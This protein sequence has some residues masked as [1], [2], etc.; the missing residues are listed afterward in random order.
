VGRNIKLSSDLGFLR[1]G[2]AVPALQVADVDFNITNIIELIKKA[3]KEGVQVLAFPE[4]AVTG[5]TIGDLVQHQALLSK[6][7]DGL[8]AI[9]KTSADFEMVLIIGLPL[10]I[11]QK[12]FNC[13]AVLNHGQILGVIPKTYL[14]SYKEF[15]EERWFASSR[16]ANSDS[17]ELSGQHV[18]FGTDILF[19]IRGI[20]SA[21]VG[22]E[23]CEDMWIPLSPHE[24]QSKAG[25]TILVNISA[26][27]EILAKADWRR[28]MLTSESGRCIAACCYVSSGI[29]E[30]T[31]DV[32]FG[33]HALI[34]ENGNILQESQRLALSPQL[35]IT[36]IDLDRL[37]NDRRMITSFHESPG[38][39]M[40]YRVIESQVNDVP[41]ARLYRSIDPHPFVP[42]DT[43]RR[44]ER[45]HDIFA[46]QVASLAKKLTGAKMEHLVLG[47][48]GGLDSTLALLVA[49]KTVDFLGLPR[50]NVY[51][52]TLPGFGTTHRT[53]D[54][55]LNLCKALG[56][57]YRKVDISG[58]CRSHMTDLGHEG[59]ED[60]VFE[61]IQARYR[62]E[63]LFNKANELKGVLLGTGDLTEV[64]LGW[65]TFSG[66]HLSHYDVNVSVP[67]TLVR[68]LIRWVAD[69]EVAGT[70]AQKILY[71]VLDTPISPELRRPSKGR[72][73]Q[74][75]EDVIGP[76]ELAD[77]Y[78]YPFVRAGTRP[79]KI[80]FLANEVRKQGLF[81]SRYTLEDLHRWL[82]SFIQRFFTNQFKRT[83]MPEGPKVGSVSL[84]PRGDWRMPSDA[85]AKLWLENL[86]EMYARLRDKS[87]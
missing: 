64:A 57:N 29:G 31:N 12:V 78:L 52:C 83:C 54:N 84:S 44:A 20:P 35:L 58:T 10:S 5:Y 22:V 55:A 65:C 28:I 75:S 25:A 62:T 67:K 17:I 24:Y 11:D 69:E 4:M 23:V 33:G 30:S 63:F 53:K 19:S 34:A 61:N 68:Y 21:I 16:D 66:D 86:E 14:P 51:A 43:A 82:K 56:V 3:G 37:L 72:I 26:S 59:Q 39:H 42:K 32:V 7:E 2:A 40:S 85:E 18:P 73:T 45:C 49:S 13:A 71:D 76:V 77:F 60:I 87:T 46:M 70:P 41:A 36:D 74:M 38:Q 47:V 27:N 81:D 8:N 1:I 48:S 80:L 79:G 15:Y 50:K 6:A 9:L